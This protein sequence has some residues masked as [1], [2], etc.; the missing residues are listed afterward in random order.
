MRYW[1][2]GRS[3]PRRVGQLV[4]AAVALVAGLTALGLLLTK[5]L[6]GSA[7]E[8]ADA[9]ADVVLARD[10]TPTWNRVTHYATLLAETRTVV[11]VGAVLFLLFLLALRRWREPLFIATVLVG[12]VAIF[13]TI[14]LLVDRHRP[15]VP[16]L[17]AAPPTSSFP[18]GHTAAAVSLYGGAAV[19]AWRTA[20][21]GLLRALAALVGIVVPVAVALSRV[22]RGMHFP[23]DVLAGALLGSSWLALVAVT[24]LGGAGGA[25]T[26]A[27]VGQRSSSSGRRARRTQNS[28]PS[29]SASTTQVTSSP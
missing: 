13:V 29:G 5:V 28:L 26:S 9:Q 24:L 17:D 2:G 1:Y 10:R 16:H 18:S 8:R 22:Y 20:R 12:E 15:P 25:A 14:T 27:S 19:V 21:R 23:T 7:F 4:A 3:L 6:R 11:V